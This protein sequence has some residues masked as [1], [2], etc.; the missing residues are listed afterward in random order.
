MDFRLK[1]MGGYQEGFGEIYA[2]LATGARAQHV[3]ASSLAKKAGATADW[4]SIGPGNVGGRV[5]S[6]LID[7]VNPNIVWLGAVTGG[8]G[9]QFD[10][11]VDVGAV[12][13]V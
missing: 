1:R 9:E 11:R 3:E 7:P 6:I 10:R 2:E 13:D 8:V 5:R 12:V 4:E